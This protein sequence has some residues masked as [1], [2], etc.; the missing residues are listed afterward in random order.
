MTL[1]AHAI[2]AI[3]EGE[4]GDPFAVLGPHR[5]ETPD[6]AAMAYRAIVPGAAGLRV[7]RAGAPPTPMER[8]HHAGFFVTVLPDRRDPFDY[9]LEVTRN[10]HVTQIEDPYRFSSHRLKGVSEKERRQIV[11]ENAARLYGLALA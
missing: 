11:R 9:R 5:V 2:R 3:V 1:D 6:G 10:G 4:H 8:V 7:L